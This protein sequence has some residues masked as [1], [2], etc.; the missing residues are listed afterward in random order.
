MGPPEVVP[1]LPANRTRFDA[2]VS[3]QVTEAQE[4]VSGSIV[5]V[6]HVMRAVTMATGRGVILLMR[7]ISPADDYEAFVPR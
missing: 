2:G 6:P 5:D 7:R 1:S 4:C 3:N